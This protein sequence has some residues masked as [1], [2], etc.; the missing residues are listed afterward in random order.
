[1]ARSLTELLDD[2]VMPLLGGGPLQVGAPLR[3]RD[4]PPMLEL[5]RE[6]Q[7]PELR[8]LRLRRGQQ[9]VADPELPD[10]DPDELQLWA[11]LYNTLVFEHPD[12]RRVWSR[13]SV[14]RRVEGTT[15]S[16]LTLSAPASVGEALMR[17]VSVGAFIDLR[18][19][20]MVVGL[21]TGGELRAM[22]QDLPRRILRVASPADGL[23]HEQVRLCEQ[24]A[25]LEAQRL[26]EDALRASP[27]TCV[28]R[29]LV[30]PP[31]WSPLWAADAFGDRAMVRAICH[32]W[33]RQRDWV[34]V[35]GAVTG[36]LLPS[37]P[38]PSRARPVPREGERLALPGAVLPTDPDV[39][40]GVVGALIHLHFLK[41]VE[42]DARL[43]VAAASRDPGVTA[44]LALPLLLPWL[45]ERTG[46][47]LGGVVQDDA[48]R[49]GRDHVDAPI[50]RRWTE[51]LDHLQELVP[52]SAVDNLLASLVSRIVQTP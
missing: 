42:L 9:L 36:A 18:R 12:R 45:G 2:F 6:L 38:N 4:L 11:G 44:F 27:L 32:E 35:G 48:Q 19:H 33:A 47:P 20:D 16:L 13:A 17:H 39:L 31:G 52:R 3:A 49:P 41:V 46:S 30:A 15:R 28:L 23:R 43:G 37:L 29:P 51:Y 40:V 1:M 25:S 21:P 50:A 14:W 26:L 7:R 5:A 34:A 22:G 10:P 24:L 8:F